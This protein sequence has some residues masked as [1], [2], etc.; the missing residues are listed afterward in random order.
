MSSVPKKS[1]GMATLLRCSTSNDFPPKISNFGQ[2]HNKSVISGTLFL[3]RLSR[4]SLPVA[5]NGLPKNV[6]NNVGK[7][8]S[9]ATLTCF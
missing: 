7:H 5:N 8:S 3:S 1:R 6:K 2:Y 9:Q 4:K